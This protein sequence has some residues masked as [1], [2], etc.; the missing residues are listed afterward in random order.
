MQL[1][2]LH[3]PLRVTAMKESISSKSCFCKAHSSICNNVCRLIFQTKLLG[4]HEKNTLGD[5][6]SLSLRDGQQSIVKILFL[7]LSLSS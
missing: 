7:S 6:R 2:L 1:G 3:L 5:K 4:E